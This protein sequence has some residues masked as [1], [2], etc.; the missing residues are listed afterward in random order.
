MRLWTVCSLTAVLLGLAATSWAGEGP[1]TAKRGPKAEQFYAVHSQMNALLGDLANL[2]LKY[3]KANEEQR[4]EIQRQ[5]K[6]LIAKGEKLEPKLVEAAKAAYAEAPN[7]DKQITDYLVR[8]LAQKVHYDDYEPAVAI[9]K[10]LMENNCSEPQ[11]PNLVGIAAFAVSDFDTAEKYLSLAEKQ[12]YYANAKAK[13]PAKMGQ[14]YL[15]LVP[16]YKQLWA[17]EQEVRKAE[18]KAGDLPRVLLKTSKGD[19]TIELFENEA[20]NTVANFIS[21]VQSRF[22]DGVVFHRVL[23]GFM[24][25]GGDP[26]GTGQGGPGYTIAD[27]CRRPDYRHHFRGTLSMAKTAQPDT[28]GSQFFLTFVP[29]PHLDGQHTVFGRVVDGMDVLAKLQRR[30]PDDPEAPRPDK[31]LEAKVLRKRPHAYKPQKMPE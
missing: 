28:G 3:R 17:K 30:D 20:P 22:Y 14:F 16:K 21:L 9:G 4:T 1:A 2:Q 19:I 6:E 25:Q 31:I 27:E 26:K 8:L 13:D 12:G 7:A 15:K 23:P 24:A 10:L 11:V 18:A 5:W 29:T